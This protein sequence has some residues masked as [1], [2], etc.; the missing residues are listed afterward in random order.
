MFM[1]L[2]IILTTFILTISWAP[3]MTCNMVI[4]KGRHDYQLP[5][6]RPFSRPCDRH[7]NITNGHKIGWTIMT[8]MKGKIK[9][10]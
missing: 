5:S 9:R 1:I 6:K 2:C 4:C 8:M 10:G 7:F 3:G